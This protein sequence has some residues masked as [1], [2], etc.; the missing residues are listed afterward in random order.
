MALW[1]GA[2]GGGDPPRRDHGDGG[3]GDLE[4]DVDVGELSLLVS[5]F[6]DLLWCGRGERER[7]R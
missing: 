1:Q 6:I 4:V 2:F 3:E 5:D 7:D